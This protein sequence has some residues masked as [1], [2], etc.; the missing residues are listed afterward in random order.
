ME[1][2]TQRRIGPILLA[3]GIPPREVYIFLTV[4]S[5]ASALT[6]F[7]NVMQPFVYTEIAAIPAAEQGRL[8]GQLMT[9]QQ[10]CVILCVGLAGALADR[11]GRKVLL[12]AAL[13]GFSMTALVFPL[14]ASIFAMVVVR[15]LFGA[16]S[17]LHT[18]SGPTKF[19]DYPDNA[20]RGKFMALVMIWM[21]VVAAVLLG[22]GGQLPGWLQAAGAGVRGAGSGTLWIAGAFGLIFAVLGAVFL[23]RDKPAP[24]TA[25]APG[26]VGML[27]GFREVMAAARG[28]RSFATLIVTAFVVRTDDAVI[29]S[30]LALWVSIE[31]AREGLGM[32]QTVGIA[33]TLTGIIRLAHLLVPPVMGPLLD[34]YDRQS[35]YLGSIAAVGLAFVGAPLVGSVQGWPIYAYAVLVGVVEAGQTICQQAFFGQEA[36]AHLRGTSYSLLAIFGT[37][38][39]IVTSIVAGHLFDGMGPTAPFTLIGALHIAAVLLCL[40][41]LV[42]S[43]ARAA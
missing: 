23:M 9:V 22:A 40:A 2:D 25:G 17:A 31:G 6:A 21:A 7:L 8:A 26:L 34:R 5:V 18:A 38:S 42:R 36:P 19:F 4:T 14:T 33:G 28:N 37:V 16:A 32:V 1:R 43:R 15:A 10:I 39:V 11:V 20:S 27:A 24:G 35:L 29:A 12:I 3:P 41:L 30:F 13:A